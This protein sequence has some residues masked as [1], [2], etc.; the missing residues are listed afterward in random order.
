MAIVLS[1][2]A[3][4]A[5]ICWV[6]DPSKP[7]VIEFLVSSGNTKSHE[8][9]TPKV[10]QSRVAVLI[11][12][13]LRRFNLNASTKLVAAMTRDFEVDIFLSLFD[14]ASKGWL[15]L[16]NAFQQDPQF[17]GLNRTG[18]QRLI[19]RR[20][21]MPGSKVG[22]IKLFDHYNTE[23][24]DI[25]FIKTMHW[26]DLKKGRQRGQGTTARSNFILLWKE[27]ESL[28]NLA[29]SQERVRC[30]YSY[31]MILRDDG[32]WVRDFNLS[33]LLRLGGVQKNGSGSGRGGHLYS[34]LCET[35]QKRIRRGGITDW[36]FLLDRPAAET[37]GKCYS[38]LAQPAA[39]GNVWLEGYQNDTLIWNSE[40]FY[41]FLA[42][43]ADVEVIEVPT[44]LLPMQRAALLDG[45]LCLYQHCDSHL[46][47]KNVPWLEPDK[48]MLTCETA[49]MDRREAG[50]ELQVIGTSGVTVQLASESSEDTPVSVLAAAAFTAA[51]RRRNVSTRAKLIDGKRVA[52]QEVKER[53]AV[54][55]SHQVTPGLAVVLVGQRPDSQ[56]YVRAKAKVGCRIFNVNFPESVSEDELMRK[57]D[58]LNQDPL[59]HGILV[60]LPLPKGINEQRV[61]DAIKVH[62]D[63]DGL[64]AENLGQLSRP[65]GQPLAIPCTPAG[66]MELLERHDVDVAGKE[67]VILGRSAIV[68]MP[69][70]LLMVRANASV[71]VCHRYTQDL[72]LACSQ[73]DV[74]VAAVGQPEFVQGD[75][76]KEGAV[77]IDVGINRVD[78][79]S[80]PRGYRL[81]G[82][83]HFESAKGR[84]SLITPVQVLETYAPNWQSGGPSMGPAV[85]TMGCIGGGDPGDVDETPAGQLCQ[86]I[87]EGDMEAACSLL[88]AS[89]QLACE[90]DKDGMLPLHWACDRGDL[91]MVPPAAIAVESKRLLP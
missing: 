18:I 51:A 76:I 53:V 82:D 39:F 19:E 2:I 89:P 44:Y 57:I 74:L 68:G 27:L 41:L 59:V 86:Q 16:S 64:T 36:I 45:K 58:E 70:A 91:E 50:L 8:F 11:A 85:S 66:C 23:Q 38:R 73:A 62:K 71:K 1:S 48:D 5:L 40:T 43:F 61:L 22:G 29:Q 65:T 37:F 21:N 55:Q 63:A 15:K 54:L 88:R 33:Q 26:W 49:E 78:D 14:A 20:L 35:G 31:V 79:S 13:T 77:V 75:W 3:Y 34:V 83:V 30:N 12:G 56:S 69:M 4:L 24:Q 28:W 17:E 46:P 7:P 10:R 90:A 67:C 87:A 60:Q 25:A 42:E 52:A 80:R 81:A 32:F 6:Q 84:A 47:S 9:E 72:H